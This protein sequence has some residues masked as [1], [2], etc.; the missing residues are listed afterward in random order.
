[1]NAFVVRKLIGTLVVLFA[2]SV[3][4]FGIIYLL[5]GDPAVSLAPP[6]A[7]PEQI[8]AIRARYQL[9]EPLYRQYV[10]WLGRALT[11]DLGT[12]IASGTDVAQL[13]RTKVGVTVQLAIASFLLAV[14]VAVPLGIAAGLKPRGLCA[15][16]LEG[17]TTLGFAVPNFWT[18]ILMI[19]LFG[20]HLKWLPT[21]GFVSFLDDPVASL[22]HLVMPSLVLSV[23]TSVVISNYLRDSIV[24]ITSME[25]VVA[26]T[27]KG[28]R[29]STVIR[30][31]ILRNALVPVL[32]I[33]MLQLGLMMAGTVITESLF[34]IP[35][36]GRLVLDAI[37][38]RDYP[39]LQGALLLVVA[40]FI[41]LN[42]ITDLLYGI[43]DPRIRVAGT[44]K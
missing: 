44:S 19:L 1:M 34:S 25:Y 40:I 5:P 28:L 21:S 41:V 11:G 23:A 42:L 4:I 17:Y 38:D 6:N 2:S 27:A 37:N 15:R 33:A 32:T 43:I 16:L 12:S 31:H 14:A 30:K 24:T 26:A 18:G 22:R 10:S 3:L 35:G 8:D 9:D 13:L 36:L 20:V 7:R 29:R 39:V